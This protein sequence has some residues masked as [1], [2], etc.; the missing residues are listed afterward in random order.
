M[1]KEVALKPIK[2]GKKGQRR[3]KQVF[4]I[5]QIITS[6]KIWLLK[7]LLRQR[8]FAKHTFS[9]TQNHNIATL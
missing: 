1:E 3:S 7:D 2:I 8:L 4:H 6:N 5:L 9:L